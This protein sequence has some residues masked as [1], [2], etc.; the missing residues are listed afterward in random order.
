MTWTRR[1]AVLAGPVLGLFFL[2][3]GAS[4]AGAA[5]QQ[6]Q[7]GE[8]RYKVLLSD[9][10]IAVTCE[11][12]RCQVEPFALD[13][14]EALSVDVALGEPTQLDDGQAVVDLP[15]AGDDSCNQTRTLTLTVAPTTDLNGLVTA[16]EVDTG[17]CFSSAFT[18]GFA[19]ELVTAPELIATPDSP[20]VLSGL[21][22]AEDVTAAE[23]GKA[24][25]GALVLVALVALPTALWNAAIDGAA[26]RIPRWR[27]RRPGNI[28]ATDDHGDVSSTWLWAASG[29]L[30]AGLIST[31]V[32]PGVGLNSG[33]ARLFGS[34]M[35]SFAIEVGLGWLA[36]FLVMRLL[37]PQARASYSFAPISL[38]VVA[39]L[40][41]FSRFTE[42]QPGIVFGLVAGVT[43]VA[44][45][46]L[47]ER[48]LE[49][50]V[51][52]AWAFVI[53]IIAWLVY[54]AVGPQT[55]GFGLFVSEAL[56]AA[57]VGG[58]AALPL[59]LLPL[60]GLP[61][62]PI[63]AWSKRVWVVA[64][65]LV[66]VAFFVVLMPFPGSWRE[67]EGS[68][69]GGLVGYLGYL[70]LGILAWLTLREPAQQDEE[71]PVHP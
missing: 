68:L 3:L 51:P 11:A 28:A 19:A 48:A 26:S 37:V 10:E 12:S 46:T 52:I 31:F 58:V 32:D 41:A 61:G 56:A 33:T 55:A 9:V 42:F 27:S 50:L 67:I 1:V 24:S 16:D 8:Y 45:E 25:G 15:P 43:F 35:S 57:V 70:V 23:V 59:V 2:A 29:V 38:L 34:L 13:A 49:R 40:V 22:S 36:V 64:Y 62:E 5:E 53:A 18:T 47:R 44:V 4:G 39:G 21:R 17:D 20:S 71:D 66:M 14:T 69:V 65:G 30:A 63:Y 7:D 54:S 60:R 6:W